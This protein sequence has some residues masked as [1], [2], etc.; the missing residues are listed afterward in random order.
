[1]SQ[2]PL[3]AIDARM[4]RHSGIGVVLRRMME[5]WARLKTPMGLVLCGDPNL[6]K[7][8]VPPGLD[9]EVV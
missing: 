1:M 7:D 6:L 2:R 8:D 3:V 5:S 9:A 4:I